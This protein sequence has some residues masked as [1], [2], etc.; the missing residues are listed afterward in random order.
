MLGGVV[1]AE[2]I[3]IF[4]DFAARC[5]SG[6]SMVARRFFVLQCTVAHALCFATACPQLLDDD[7][8]GAAGAGGAI[9]NA[10]TSAGGSM[11]GSGSISGAAGDGSAQ[12]GAAAV[13]RP[14]LDAGDT[15]DG[16]DAGAPIPTPCPQGALG[17]GATCHFL[18]ASPASWRDAVQACVDAGRLL[19]QIDSAEED[20][21]IAA[22]SPWSVWIGASD[23][24][25]DGSF[26][27]SD[28][29]AIVFSNWGPAQ[30]DAYAGPDCVEK[31]EGDERWYDQP[32][33]VPKRYV[34]ESPARLP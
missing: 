32:C 25:V 18:S 17:P 1:P 14:P 8:D 34:C 3:R 10:G 11:A 16:A 23:T 31:R 22:L 2:G 26:V 9:G 13:P 20:A 29:S 27:W 4:A 28:G 33:D 19:L 5:D 24:V 6:P 12:A 30:P 21:F 15:A 7:F